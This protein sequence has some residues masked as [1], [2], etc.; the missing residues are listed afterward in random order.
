VPAHEFSSTISA[1]VTTSKALVVYYAHC[2][3][4]Q[5]ISARVDSAPITSEL[6]HEIAARFIILSDFNNR[7]TLINRLLRL[8]ALA[9]AESRRRNA[10]SVLS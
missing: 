2:Q 5:A 3:Q 7:A 4:K 1:L 8:R 10:D 6:V 9:R